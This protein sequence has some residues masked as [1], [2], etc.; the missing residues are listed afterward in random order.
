MKRQII[1][2]RLIFV[3]AVF[4][5]MA[6]LCKS[7][8][9]VMKD[10]EIHCKTKDGH[11]WMEV[12]KDSDDYYLIGHVR[13]T[14]D[15][16]ADT[17]ALGHE[18]LRVNPKWIYTLDGADGDTRYLFIYSRGNIFFWDVAV[19]YIAGKDGAIRRGVF[20]VEDTTPDEVDVMWWDARIDAC[21]SFPPDLEGYPD[22]YRDGIRFDP[23][24]Q[25]LYV[26]VM[27]YYGNDS[28]FS[29]CPIYTRHFS[30]VKFDGRDFVYIGD[31]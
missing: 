15:S 2:L 4:L 5:S 21:E 16:V 17:L 23:A 1:I 24:A 8:S 30:I 18:M 29:G 22:F 9:H 20:R 10:G 26:P 19:V 6:C 31:E 12:I 27:D 7:H 25:M 3:L 28:E 13:N 14:V 11:A